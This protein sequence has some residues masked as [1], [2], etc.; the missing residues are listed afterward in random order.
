VKDHT[1][2][3]WFRILQVLVALSQVAFGVTLM[4]NPAA[5]TSVWP[6][7]LTTI[8]TR[9]LAASTLVSV[10]LE[11]VPSIVNRWSVTRIPV[12]MLL[13]YRV[14]QLLAGLIHLDRFDF[15]RPVTWNYFGGGSIMLLILAFVLSRRG[16]LGQPVEGTPKWLRGNAPLSLGAAGKATLRILGLVFAGLGVSFIILGAQA[17]PLWFE[18][19]GKLTPLTARLFASPTIGLALALWLITL[20][21]HW[22]EIAIPSIGM[23]TFGSIATASLVVEAA[24]IAPPTPLGYVTAAVPVILFVLGLFLLLPSRS[25]ATAGM[26]PPRH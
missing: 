7:P 8:T 14:F 1:L 6:W 3:T 5:I 15:S 20:A 22:R 10:P 18:A 13:T 9:V 16:S 24:S 19:P 12:V 11:I 25:A 21:P 26:L 4:I 23:A 2:P 17:A